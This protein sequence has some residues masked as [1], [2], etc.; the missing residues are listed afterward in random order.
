[1]PTTLDRVAAT[2]APKAFD[3]QDTE[4]ARMLGLDPRDVRSRAAVL[5]ARAYDLDPLMK[6]VVVIPKAGPYITRDGL[7]HVAHRSGQLDGIVVDQEPLLTDDGC[8]FARVSVWRKD[9]RHPFTF[10]GRYP[11]KGGNEKYAPEMALVRAE[12]HALRRAF[13]I[14]GLPSYDESVDV[15]HIPGELV[16]PPADPDTGEVLPDA[17]PEETS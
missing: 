7:L 17:F 4:M 12:S 14:V 10:P 11:A 3:D 16:D 8:W 9:M 15:D 1:M 6:H 5:I 13:A 2:R